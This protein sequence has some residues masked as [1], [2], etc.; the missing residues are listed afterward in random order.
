MTDSGKILRQHM[1]ISGRV[2][3]VGFRYRAKYVASTLGLTG[4]VRN[5]WDGTVELEIQGSMEQMNRMLSL[6]N[7]GTYIQIED[8]KRTEI[9][10]EE[11]ES[12][13]YVR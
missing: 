2:Q 6:V 10:L 4:W 8:I 7:Q 5:N 3:G 9:P 13:F 11:S 1:K 12:G